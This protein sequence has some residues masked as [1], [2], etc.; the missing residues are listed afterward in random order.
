MVLKDVNGRQFL[1]SN[2][3]SKKAKNY[4]GALT[5]PF[6]EFRYGAKYVEGVDHVELHLKVVDRGAL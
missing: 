2:K 6:F 1:I 4:E 3:E 5:L